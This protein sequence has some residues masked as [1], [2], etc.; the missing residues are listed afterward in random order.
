MLKDNY[1][2]LSL[3]FMKDSNIQELLDLYNSGKLEIAEKKAAEL[4]KENPKNFIIYN[5]LGAILSGQNKMEQ[6]ISNYK[7]SIKINPNYAEGYNNLG[8]ELHKLKKVELKNTLANIGKVKK[9]FKWKRKKNLTYI[10]NSVI[11]N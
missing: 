2:L 7:K 11:N 9:S 1:I 6:A 5:I 10:L 3:V 8:S 4:L